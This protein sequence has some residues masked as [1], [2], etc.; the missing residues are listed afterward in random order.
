MRWA[1][2]AIATMT[3]VALAQSPADVERLPLGRS[4]DSLLSGAE[5]AEAAPAE[6]SAAGEVA[7]A[8]WPLA[9]VVGTILVLAF[10]TK[11]LAR[12]RGGVMGA[13]G[14]GGRA[15]SGVVEVLGRFPIARGQT[16]ILM[17]IDRRVLVLSQTLTRRD[18]RLEVLSELTCPDEI[19]SLVRKCADDE[20]RSAPD[21]FTERLTS[22]RR[23]L[24]SD[25]EAERAEI[26]RVAASVEA[27]PAGRPAER[28]RGVEELRIREIEAL[29]AVETSIGRTTAEHDELLEALR[30]AAGG[31]DR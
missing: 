6:A 21:A 20:R 9:A 23:A 8:L 10:V 19:A 13:I 14:A 18:R 17:R 11:K 2:A 30:V 25:P 26:G 1:S 29:D 16:L 7:A 3:T 27:K 4:T 12:G 15:P 28:L 31:S 24:E 22:A 5:A